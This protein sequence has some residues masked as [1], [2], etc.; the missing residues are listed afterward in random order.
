[1]TALTMDKTVIST[2]V[3]AHSALRKSLGSCVSAMKLGSVI[4][5]MKVYEML[6]KALMA[7]TKV[8]PGKGSA[9]TQANEHRRENGPQEGTSRWYVR[10]SGG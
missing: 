2:M 5:S 7:A 8:V 4:C 6:R 9:V 3:T 1:M 10:R